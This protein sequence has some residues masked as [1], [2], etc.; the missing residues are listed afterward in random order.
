MKRLATYLYR[1]TW[2]LFCI[3]AVIYFTFST[4]TGLTLVCNLLTRLTPGKLELFNPKGILR[5]HFTIQELHYTYKQTNANANTLD[6]KWSPSQLWHKKILI[7]YINAKDISIKAMNKNN[8]PASEKNI[9]DYISWLQ[10]IKIEN[11]NLSSLH[12]QL[13]STSHIEI[14]K[15]LIQNQNNGEQSINIQSPRYNN[16]KIETING[17]I[18]SPSLK[19]IFTSTNLVINN[20][21]IDQYIIPITKITVTTQ[22]LHNTLDVIFSVSLSQKNVMRGELSFPQHPTSENNHHSIAGKL[23]FSFYKLDDLISSPYVKN[24]QGILQGSF[25]IAGSIS[26][27]NFSGEIAISHASLAIPTLGILL[28]NMSLKSLLNGN[29]LHLTGSLSS[30]VGHINLRADTRVYDGIHPVQ[31]HLQGDNFTVMNLPRYKIN[32]SPELIFTYTKHIPTLTGKIFIPFVN[33]MADDNTEVVTLPGDV[34]FSDKKQQT[35]YL[36]LLDMKIGLLLGDNISVRYQDLHAWLTGHLQLTQIPGG[37]PIANG[38]LLITKGDYRIYNKLFTINQGRLIY[39]GGILRNPGL[40]IRALQNIEPLKTSLFGVKFSANNIDTIKVGVSVQGTLDKPNVTLVS[41]PPMTQDDILSYI[42]F[43]QPQSSLNAAST[44]PLL[45][46]IA[47]SSGMTNSSDATP[48]TS[49]AILKMG[50]FNPLQMLSARYQ[51]TNRW[52]LQ[53]EANTTETGADLIYERELD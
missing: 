53:T 14:K 43:G 24:I 1:G 52:I 2:I 45:G 11:I 35:N 17:I 7:N 48:A 3:F 25:D 37:L 30:G 23:N 10:Y 26:R 50:L 46:V 21:S 4:Q 16:F 32:L 5:S 31:I 12:L 27:P 19:N 40:N 51:I 15:L 38:E 49:S 33:I 18:Y 44:L 20:I 42:V 8:S 34:R 36:S 47:D 6:I 41:E 13:S 9:Y 29:Q 22:S 28:R 39:T